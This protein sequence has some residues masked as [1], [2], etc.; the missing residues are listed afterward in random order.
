MPVGY[1]I[2]KT[3][4]LFRLRTS[5]GCVSLM[6]K[7]KRQHF[8]GISQLLVFAAMKLFFWFLSLSSLPQQFSYGADV[9]VKMMSQ[10]EAHA[11][12]NVILNE[13]AL[14]FV[15]LPTDANGDCG[16]IAVG[17]DREDAVALLL[18]ESGDSIIRGCLSNEIKAAFY[19][20]ELHSLFKIRNHRTQAKVL[21]EKYQK[22]KS[23]RTKQAQLDKTVD[24][25]CTD[26]G[27]YKD[28]INSYYGGGGWLTIIPNSMAGI[29]VLG[30]MSALD[31]LAMKKKLNVFIWQHNGNEELVLIH[32]AIYADDAQEKSVH[33]LHTYAS[34][35]SEKIRNHFPI[36]QRSRSKREEI[37][38]QKEIEEGKNKDTCSSVVKGLK[39]FGKRDL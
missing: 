9:A 6:M 20:G 26:E 21:F 22:I 5:L 36:R 35:K 1:R 37:G 4:P 28:Y 17:I 11:Q 32:R 18:D 16:F 33:M 13:E 31:A 38:S 24:V 27:I 29:Y 39:G 30:N 8:F 10:K 19:Q 23:N 12:Y 2:A 3:H 34:K 25:L 14:T 15:E 7:T